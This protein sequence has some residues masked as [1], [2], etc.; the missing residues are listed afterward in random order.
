MLTQTQEEPP[1]C[2]S[3]PH[4][5]SASPTFLTFSPSHILASDCPPSGLGWVGSWLRLTLPSL[6]VQSQSFINFRP[7]GR[8]QAMRQPQ[9]P[10]AFRLW[11]LSR[12]TR[13]CLSPPESHPTRTFSDPFSRLN[14]APRGSPGTSANTPRVTPGGLSGFEPKFGDSW[15][16]GATEDTGF[17]SIYLPRISPNPQKS[18]RVPTV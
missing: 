9:R 15:R 11:A 10:P 14:L 8:E 2:P 16:S 12:S 6:E 4:P 1:V 5:S 7:R 17:D 18:L 3:P 13:C